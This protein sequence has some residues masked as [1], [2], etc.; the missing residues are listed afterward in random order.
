MTWNMMMA[1]AN[2]GK[3]S[4]LSLNGWVQRLLIN[5][6]R[7]RYLL[8][9][10]LRLR[11]VLVLN[12]QQLLHTMQLILLSTP[13]VGNFDGRVIAVQREIYAIKSGILSAQK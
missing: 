4:V 2:G 13:A 6:S 1:S 3:I 8:V 9:L 5:I 7:I 11:W 12:L 10:K